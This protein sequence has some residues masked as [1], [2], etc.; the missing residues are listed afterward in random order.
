MLGNMQQILPV[1][2]LFSWTVLS[3][4]TGPSS[5]FFSSQT[6]QSELSPTIYVLRS[7]KQIFRSCYKNLDFQTL[8]HRMV[9]RYCVLNKKQTTASIEDMSAGTYLKKSEDNKENRKRKNNRFET[10]LAITRTYFHYI[11]LYQFK[12]E[13][14]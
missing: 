7:V 10:M 2:L 14:V 6:P 9:K 3:T 12:R 13:N 5:S 8:K 1:F 4:V 11:A